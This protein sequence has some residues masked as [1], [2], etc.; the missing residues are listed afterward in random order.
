MITP[1]SLPAADAARQRLALLATPTGALGRLGE[2]AV[3]WASVQ[4]T[5][6]PGAVERVRVVVL[7]GD[8]SLKARGPVAAA[9]TPWLAR[10][11]AQPAPATARR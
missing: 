9:V 2:L 10:V 1:P 3:W 7:A 8:H 4:G 5:C 11:L 6:P